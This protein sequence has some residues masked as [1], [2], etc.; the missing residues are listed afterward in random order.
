MIVDQPLNWV[1]ENIREYESLSVPIGQECR[2][3]RP[4]KAN[5]PINAI[6]VK[7]SIH[8]YIYV[9]ILLGQIHNNEIKYI[10]IK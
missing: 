5:T 1:V 4:L 2:S 6:S 9:Y 10:E 7:Y 8:K 3:T